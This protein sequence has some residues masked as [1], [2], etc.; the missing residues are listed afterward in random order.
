MRKALLFDLG[1]T[2]VRYFERSE[3]P[4]ILEQSILEVRR[5]LQQKGPLA[6]CT[7]TM[8]HRVREEDHEAPDYR[9]R[10]LEGRL[11]RIFE[12]DATQSPT[13]VDAM[14]RWFT[15]PIFARGRC[16]EDALPVLR[17][18]RAEGV[19]TAIVSNTPWGSPGALWREELARLGLGAWVDAAVFC[20]DVG[21]RKPAR[22]ILERALGLLGVDP[23]DCLFIGDDPRWDLAGPRAMGMEAILID[24]EGVISE[25]AEE[26]IRYLHELWGVLQRR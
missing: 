13:V 11:G 26:S 5:H 14:C 23:Q 12:V 24:R 19:R 1:N 22:P 2:L 4:A 7:E 10:P 15:Q 25:P 17:Q 6:V 20:T 8:W 21:W 3:F 18:L 9:V 16:Y